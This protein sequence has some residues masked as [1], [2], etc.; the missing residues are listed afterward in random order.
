LTS[1]VKG[2]ELINEGKQALIA[3]YNGNLSII[4]LETLK[5]T[6]SHE[7]VGKG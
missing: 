7:D 4:D 5:I 2:I 6:Q 1:Y 3:E